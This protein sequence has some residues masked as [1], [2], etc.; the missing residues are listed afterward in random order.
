MVQSSTYPVGVDLQDLQAAAL[1]RQPNLYLHLQPP[2]AQHGLIQHVSPVGHANQQ[3][4]VQ[5][6]HAVN[7]HSNGTAT[8]MSGPAVIGVTMRL[9]GVGQ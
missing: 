7:L 4:V 1:I 8:S 6:V 3:D 2:W 9:C 5:R